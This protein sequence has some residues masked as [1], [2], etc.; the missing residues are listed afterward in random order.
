M[1]SVRNL[2]KQFPA[3]DGKAP[4]PAVDGISFDVGRGEFFTLLGPSGCGKTTTLQCVA[5]LETPT[6]GTIEMD[7]VAVFASDRHVLVPANRRN[8]GMVFQSY[9][10]W[11]HLSVFDNVAFPLVH[12]AIKTPSRD[13]RPR[14]M[15]AL[16]LVKLQD[17]ADRP[18]PHL[19]GGQQQRVA[20]ARAL[21][22]EPKLLLLDEPLSNLDAKLRD[23]M[24]VEIR[25][26][27]KSLGI[28]TIFV[29]HDQLEAMSMSDTIVLMQ[30]GRIIQQGPPRDVYL[31]P[32]AAFTA[33]FMGRS[34]LLPGKLN[35]NRTGIVTAFGEVS[36]AVSGSLAAG[37]DAFLV[38]RPHVLGVSATRPGVAAANVFEA[39]VER[40]S[41][42]GDTVEADITI[43]ATR[44]RAALDP[45]LDVADGTTVW[46][47]FP[48][49]RC[50]VVPAGVAVS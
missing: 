14:V 28:T 20:L 36:S 43:G 34:N 25:Q 37:A 46:I 21:V 44:L 10:I 29:T 45:Y 15:K 32:T 9:A 4:A 30:S 35:A 22:N 42:L 1:L 48:A 7:G 8:L 27:V 31:R 5:G 39:K 6:S 49:E 33:D 12:G 19:S 26:L 18:S 40:Q 47:T 16:S 3:R 17:F 41:F 11:P 24:R 23:A 2:T 50:V 13:V 38:V